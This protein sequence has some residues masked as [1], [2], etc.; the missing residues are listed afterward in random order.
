MTL[1][2]LISSQPPQPVHQGTNPGFGISYSPAS[3]VL[4]ALSFATTT[5]IMYPDFS[6]WLVVAAAA[7]QVSCSVAV[8]QYEAD[9]EEVSDTM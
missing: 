6:V 5:I 4:T 1:V 2:A 3:L 8:C 7:M 9:Q